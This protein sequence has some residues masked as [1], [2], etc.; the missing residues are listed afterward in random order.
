MQEKAGQAEA[1]TEND[2]RAR[3]LYPSY[4]K[5]QVEWQQSQTSRSS[6]STCA[7]T[8][9]ALTCRSSSA[10]PRL[11]PRGRERDEMLAKAREL[12][13]GGRDDEALMHLRDVVRTSP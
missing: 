11:R 6:P 9:T 13:D 4:A 3:K 10:R 7:A 8:S 12:Y 2:N 5:A 1:A